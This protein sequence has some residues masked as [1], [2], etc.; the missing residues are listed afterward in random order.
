M[1][2][3]NNIF[4][5]TKLHNEYKKIL[6]DTH[7]HLNKTNSHSI[8][9]LHPKNKDEVQQCLK[10]ANIYKLPLFIVSTGKNWGYN[11][12]YT[13]NPPP[14]YGILILSRLNKIKKYNE[15][16][17][18]VT[19]EPGVTFDQLYKFLQIK[20]SRLMMAATGASPHTSIL[21]HALERG[22]S[23]GAVGTSFH[24]TCGY[25][26]I[27]PNGEI[28]YTDHARFLNSQAKELS[29]NS[30][31]PMLNGL[32]TQ[33]NFGVITSMTLYLERSLEYTN[34]IYYYLK[35][36]SQLPLF[37]NKIRDLKRKKI[38]NGNSLLANKYR[39]LTSMAQ[40][41]WEDVKETP[42]P[43]SSLAKL[44]K[45]WDWKGDWYGELA[46]H[47]SHELI[48]KT[49]LS[50]LKKELKNVVSGMV[51]L[52]EEKV[53]KSRAVMRVLDKQNNN[54]M[55]LENLFF[56][57]NLL[58]VPSN[59][60]IRSLYWRKKIPIPQDL[61]PIRDKCGVYWINAEIPFIGKDVKK[62]NAICSQLM[63]DFGFE[64]NIGFHLLTD[65]VVVLI[66]SILFD[67][68]DTNQRDNARKCYISLN[69]KLAKL[70][71]YPYRI[72]PFFRNIFPK[73]R[74]RYDWIIDSLKKALDPNNILSPI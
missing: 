21:A 37:I 47:S 18:Y 32:F 16:L 38:I 30:F 44:T 67:D 20:K 64:P 40:Y 6:G 26:I 59:I 49:Q 55:L 56:K 36:N 35:N 57:S 15:G 5:I 58:G 74:G 46:L 28:L 50:I 43:P 69:K 60:P 7:V 3:R 31:G 65:H 9:T 2:N 14:Q 29:S 23:K 68:E 12:S 70:G 11:Y 54:E 52:D 48:A 45:E 19:I 13:Y 27:L 10:I 39:I 33:S 73:S 71:Y 24:Q 17:G 72:N 25:E 1:N 53:I 62:I 34:I 66:A 63:L 22:I 41:P 8:F 61:N 4:D 51:V 42:L